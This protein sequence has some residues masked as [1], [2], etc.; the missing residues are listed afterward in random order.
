MAEISSKN[1][2]HKIVFFFQ[3]LEKK[4]GIKQFCPTYLARV[5]WSDLEYNLSD[6]EVGYFQYTYLTNYG[7]YKL[8]KHGSQN[9]VFF[10][11]APLSDAIKIGQ[12]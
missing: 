9:E 2:G 6:I 1:R 4:F 8:K 10:Q 5:F 7:L 11:T 3:S 12:I